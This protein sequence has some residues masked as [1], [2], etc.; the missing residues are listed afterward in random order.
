MA[1]VALRLD[2]TCRVVDSCGMLEFR[3]D[4]EDV[5]V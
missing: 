3:L 5:E 1:V 4:E 2:G